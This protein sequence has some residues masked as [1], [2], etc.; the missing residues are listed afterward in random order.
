MSQASQKLL[1]IFDIFWN[2]KAEIIVQ[3]SNQY[4]EGISSYTELLQ[5]YSGQTAI[6]NKRYFEQ[7][8]LFNQ[9]FVF[10]QVLCPALVSR[11]I[12]T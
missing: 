11:I 7:F 9:I 4:V 10:S 3:P 8:A 2:P 5:V 6:C 1:Y 12:L